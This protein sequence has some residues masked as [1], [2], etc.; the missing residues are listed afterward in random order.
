MIKSI[1]PS[2]N[3]VINN[4]KLHSDKD[5]ALIIDSVSL[6]FKKW[7]NISFKDRAKIL[8]DIAHDLMLNR[9][10]HSR[11]IS[12]EIGKPIVEFGYLII[13][14]IIHLNF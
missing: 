11:M 12:T 13:L 3:S 2:T 1:N 8:N 5:I 4:Y 14:L 6:E 9:E 7:K 10:I